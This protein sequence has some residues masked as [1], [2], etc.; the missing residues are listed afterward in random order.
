MPRLVDQSNQ[1]AYLASMGPL[2]PL[3]A[4]DSLSEIMV[5]G[6]DTVY[7]EKDGKLLLTDVHFND[8][9]PPPPGHRYHR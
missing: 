1:L 3:L 4:D 8:E 5:N 9:G 2:Q 6:H 7:V